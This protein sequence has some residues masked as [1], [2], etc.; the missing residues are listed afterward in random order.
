MSWWLFKLAGWLVLLL[1]TL[2]CLTSCVIMHEQDGEGRSATYA[3]LGGK[4]AYR[5]G[6]G[7]M[8]HHE[9][10]FRDATVAATALAAGYYGAATARATE[11]TNQLALKEATK[12]AAAKETTKR[13]AIEA[14]AAAHGAAIGAELPGV[15]PASPPPEITP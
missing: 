13:A 14:N 15:V 7:V 2:V 6:F 10:S 8:H 3:S 1:L 9:K 5:K 12:Q 4:G 11:T